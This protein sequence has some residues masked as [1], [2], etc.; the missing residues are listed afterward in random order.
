MLV[1]AAVTGMRMSEI[2]ERVEGCHLPPQ[3]IG[4]DRVR[5]RI[6]G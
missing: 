5:Y 3:E 1:T 6:T 2:V 4:R